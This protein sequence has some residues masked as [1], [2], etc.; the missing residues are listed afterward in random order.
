[1]EDWRRLKPDTV[2]ATD[3]LISQLREQSSTQDLLDT[4]LYAKRLL[5]ES[6]QAFL[7]A[8]LPERCA[9]FHE[10]RA[11]LAS[12][13]HRWYE[14]RLPASYLEVPYGSRLHEE[15]FSILLQRRNE[16]VEAGLLRVISADSVH[17]ERRVRELRELGINITN[18]KGNGTDYYV[19]RSLDIDHG[20]I[21]SIIKNT[22]KR[23]RHQHMP[24]EKLLSILDGGS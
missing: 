15:L 1:M 16:E 14:D 5:A 3:E 4:Y 10:L 9:E 6:M 18:R 22:A 17:T 21:K 24:E 20:M 7:R 13:M 2:I 12:E 23:K 8:T 19:L 11:E